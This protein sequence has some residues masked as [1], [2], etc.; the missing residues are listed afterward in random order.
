MD[1][2]EMMAQVEE[3]M[4]PGREFFTWEQLD[5][6][7]FAGS[8]M[9]RKPEGTLRVVAVNVQSRA[10]AGDA[11]E[12]ARIM[13]N[14]MI[15]VGADIS[16]VSELNVHIGRVRA[17][18]AVESAYHG[19]GYEARCAE[20]T[21]QNSGVMIV[22]KS[23]IHMTDFKQCD[24]GRAL[25]AT[26]M[27]RAEGGGCRA[28]RVGVVY[29]VAGGEN[30]WHM[31]VEKRQT[32]SNLNRFVRGEVTKAV[33]DHLIPLVGR[34][35]NSIDNPLVDARGTGSMQRDE[36]LVSSL[37]LSHGNDRHL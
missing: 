23:A 28:M 15:R 25:F 32:E 31:P 16:L 9:N 12:Q 5:A 24:D 18:A 6:G 34:D 4:D 14:Y 29:G 21:Q 36:S 17:K 33:R 3:C 11:R 8:D 19:T 7:R 35:V 37:S 22:W 13:I 10:A 30:T 26:A 2:E 27:A 20:A 1:M